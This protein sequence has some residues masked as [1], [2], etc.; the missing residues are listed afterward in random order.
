MEDSF[1]CTLLVVPS[2]A[3]ILRYLYIHMYKCLILNALKGIC[4][5]QSRL[6][7]T[8]HGWSDRHSRLVFI[9]FVMNPVS[10]LLYY[11]CFVE[12]GQTKFSLTPNLDELSAMY[13]FSPIANID[14]IRTPTLFLIGNI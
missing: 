10:M 3:S 12:A 5:T 11:R 1:P 4:S 7:Y 8:V 13:K 9:L 6:Q 2:L 14:K